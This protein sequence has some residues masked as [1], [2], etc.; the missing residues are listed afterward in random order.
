VSRYIY[1]GPFSNPASAYIVKERKD[2]RAEVYFHADR[3]ADGSAPKDR[4]LNPRRVFDDAEE[5]HE[6]I[7]QTREFFE[8][9][10]SQYLEENSHEIA[11]MEAYE[12]WRNE[13]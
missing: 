3:A 13:Q 4:P 10:H 2:G 5:A 1:A 11:R 12:D 9:D 7:E 6:W 8:E